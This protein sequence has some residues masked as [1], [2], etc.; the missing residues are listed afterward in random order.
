MQHKHCPKCDKTLPIEQFNK[1]KTKASGY[2][3]WCKD[4]KQEDSKKRLLSPEVKEANRLRAEERRKLAPE[5]VREAMQK[6]RDKV[7][8]DPE[9]S[10]AL[11]Q[12]K[13]EYYYQSTYGLTTQQ[14][15]DMKTAQ[16]YSC[17][18]CG[19]VFKST[20]DAHVDHN[21]TTGKVREV[22]CS[23]CNHGIGKFAESEE[24]LLKAIEY[25]RKHA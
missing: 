9:K 12:Q 1:S 14:V 22:L 20:K 11:K 21:H 2:Q 10:L 7:K 19:D 24:R 5:K 15:E 6:H 18:I 23:A 3:S 13:Q 8:Q 16:K 4:C 17:A 25:L